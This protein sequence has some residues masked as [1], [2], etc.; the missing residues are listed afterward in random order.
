VGRED[1]FCGPQRLPPK[2][3]KLEHA[4]S[5]WRPATRPQGKVRRAGAALPGSSPGRVDSQPHLGRSSHLRRQ[6]LHGRAYTKCGKN[7]GKGDGQTIVKHVWKSDKAA[8]ACSQQ[9]RNKSDRILTK[10]C[11]AFCCH[12][13]QPAGSSE[14]LRTVE[15]MKSASCDEKTAWGGNVEVEALA[16]DWGERPVC[17]V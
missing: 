3:A 1:P 7:R 6:E 12:F 2:G 4:A 17:A 13:A 11:L 15:D 8:T 10:S 5:R 14:L 9:E 16:W